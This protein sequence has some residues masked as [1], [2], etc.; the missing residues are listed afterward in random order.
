MLRLVVFD[1][2]GVLV[3]ACEWHKNA[4]NESLLEI[5]NYTISEEDHITHY[6]GLPTKIKL[7]R[8]AELGHISR[9]S[10]KEIYFTK[11]EKTKDII[12]SHACIDESKIRLMEWLR[13]Q[14]IYIAC[15]TNSIHET[16]HMM[17]SKTGVLDFLELL[18]T[19]QDVINPK[20]NPEGYYKAL[21]HFG[22]YSSESMII[23]DSPKGIQA[24][25]ATGCKVMQ[26]ENATKVN[27]KN[28]KEFI[29][30]NF[31]SHGR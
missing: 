10:I 29:D 20:P 4:L 25:L 15:F 28:V 9:D 3:D 18:V 8:M 19:N 21:R 7:E 11:Q 6:N 24:A 26:V 2:D 1:M 13:D 22:V 12:I 27:I 23:E 30:E 31:N 17:L 5:S 16:A 14:G